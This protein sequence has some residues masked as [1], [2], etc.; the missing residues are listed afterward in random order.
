MR[1][2]DKL[3][4]RDAARFCK[5]LLCRQK[6][7]RRLSVG[8]AMVADM[9]EMVNPNVTLSC[10]QSLSAS[11]AD[12]VAGQASFGGERIDERTVRA[13]SEGNVVADR[14]ERSLSRAGKLSLMSKGRFCCLFLRLDAHSACLPGRMRMV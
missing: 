4:N 13:K 12:A 2:D 5:N 10:H 14:H 9:A 8:A 1:R 6:Q 3:R 7:G 11:G